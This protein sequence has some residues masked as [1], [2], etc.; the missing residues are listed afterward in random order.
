[1]EEGSKKYVY[2]IMELKSYAFLNVNWIVT[3]CELTGDY[4]Q[5]PAWPLIIISFTGELFAYVFRLASV[6]VK[7]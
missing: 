3:L 2:E 6:V 7:M 1:L 5:Q 4:N